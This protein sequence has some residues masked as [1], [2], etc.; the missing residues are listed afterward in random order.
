MLSITVYTHASVGLKMDIR[1]DCNSPIYAEKFVNFIYMSDSTN[2]TLV[3]P[4]LC[5][6]NKFQPKQQ[7]FPFNSFKIDS[8]IIRPDECEIRMIFDSTTASDDRD[9]Y[10]IEFYSDS[11]NKSVAMEY[12]S[13]YVFV[14]EFDISV[15]LNYNITLDDDKG[16]IH[17]YK[18]SEINEVLIVNKNGNLLYEL[19]DTDRDN[20]VVGFKYYSNENNKE[21][22]EYFV[23]KN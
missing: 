2:Y 10:V 13:P 22:V 7:F 16:F 8:T 18:P 5:N 1:G 4:D 17:E 9:I 21:Y 15:H 12:A 20:M 14:N 11:L 3:L 19:Q 6:S 23:P